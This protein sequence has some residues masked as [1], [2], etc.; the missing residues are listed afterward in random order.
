MTLAIQV[1]LG[2]I[3]SSQALKTVNTNN[4]SA[5]DLTCKFALERNFAGN[6]DFDNYTKG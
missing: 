5:N 2:L 1:L 3:S 6:T 4:W